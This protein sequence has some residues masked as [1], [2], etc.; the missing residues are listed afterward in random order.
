MSEII[1]STTENYKSLLQQYC[2][3]RHLSNPGYETTQHGPPNEPSWTVTVKYGQSTY[4]T[5]EPIRGSKKLAEQ[6]AAQ[7]ILET[8]ES[9]Q[10]AFLAGEPDDEVGLAEGG[11]SDSEIALPEEKTSSARDGYVPIELVTSALGIA[12][13]RLSELRRGTRYRE[14]IESRQ[15]SQTFAKNLAELTIMIVRAVVNAAEEANIKLGYPKE[16]ERSE[17]PPLPTPQ[18]KQTS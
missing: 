4:T 3:V 11:D 9:R 6:I 1:T 15:A 10:E 8:I 5:P 12:N 2:Q 7:Q 18:S 16:T 17:A 14:S 13:H